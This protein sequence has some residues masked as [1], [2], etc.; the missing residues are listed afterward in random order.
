MSKYFYEGEVD[1]NESVVIYR[2]GN[3]DGLQSDLILQSGYLEAATI[4]IDK[5]KQQKRTSAQEDGL[6]YPL[7][8][9]YCCLLEFSLKLVIRTL[10]IHVDGCHCKF[11][12]H[13]PANKELKDVLHSHNLLKLH[14]IFTSI[15]NPNIPIHNFKELSL[16][17]GIVNVFE[18]NGI[19][20]FSSRYH[21]NKNKQ[22]HL[23]YNKQ[24]NVNLIALH[25]DM[26]KVVSFV[27]NYIHDEN[28]PL[29][30]LGYF[31][32]QG[33]NILETTYKNSL[34]HEPL[35]APFQVTEK[36]GDVKSGSM[37]LTVNELIDIALKG[38]SHEEEVFF[39]KITK[40]PLNEKDAILKCL[41]LATN[42]ITTIP[43]HRP[44]VEKIILNEEI[45][46]YKHLYKSGL[47][48]L[49]HYICYIKEFTHYFQ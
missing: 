12:N 3:E 5:I 39:E 34:K 18:S 22:T 41:R 27:N 8:N 1:I 47:E 29:C 45:Y 23:L 20:I 17:T 36:H 15:L 33:L 10:Q 13:V 14:N 32:D 11:L 49:K 31:N 46:E 21:C 6:A 37:L 26:Q 42:P 30:E 43:L 16:I 2:Y 48:K 4:I 35:F 24:I 7:L 28:F 25:D 40:L 44:S 19:N 38:H 9:L